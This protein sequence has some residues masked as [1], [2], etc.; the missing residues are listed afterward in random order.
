MYFIKEN[1]W[2]VRETPLYRFITNGVRSLSDF[3]V[4]ASLANISEQ[5]AQNCLTYF[6]SFQRLAR[7]SPAEI[8]QALGISPQSAMRLL[9]AFEL[10]RRKQEEVSRKPKMLGAKD[11]A[12]Y[13]Q[14]IFADQSQ[15]IFVVLFINRQN[16]IIAEEI[17]FKG[18][19]SATIVDSKVIFRAACNHLAS[20][21]II[22]HN[23]PSNNKI[24]SIADK[25][26]TA[27]LKEAGDLLDIL[28]LDHLI[29]TDDDYFSFADE[30]LM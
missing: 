14:T 3:E 26:L 6:Q 23:H 10:G 2:E 15:E 28:V 12:V 30:G 22:G 29:I 18:G 4:L 17:M 27:Q 7:S 16:E 21:I 5:Q 24:P 8:Q 20:A 1:N 13:L 11:V 25:K 9:C 19:V